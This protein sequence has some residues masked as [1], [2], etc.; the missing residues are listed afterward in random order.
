M[1]AKLLEKQNFIDKSILER[2]Q[3]GFAQT[4]AMM[5]KFELALAAIKQAVDSKPEW[6]GLRKI[7]ARIYAMA[8]EVNDALAQAEQ[9][10]EIAPQVVEGLIWFADFLTGLGKTDEAEDKL[11]KSIENHADNLML[12]AKFAEILM[13]NGKEND[14][15]EIAESIKSMLS[16][17]LSDAELVEAAGVLEKIGESG[18]VQK[19]LE[20]RAKKN[21]S[22][23][24]WIDLAGYEYRQEQF[25]N[26]LE[27]LENMEVDQD[28]SRLVNCLKADVLVK[29]GN[30]ENA[31][32][33][34]NAGA[35]T[36]YE[37]D[38]DQQMLFAPDQW[39]H[40]AGSLNPA[41]ELQTKIFLLQGKAKDSLDSVKKWIDFDADNNAARIMA[42]ESSFALGENPGQEY[43]QNIST[44]D[45]LEGDALHLIALKIE[46]LLDDDQV[47]DAQTL[48]EK[49]GNENNL[50]LKTVGIRIT[51]LSG[52]LAE[53][54]NN[55]DEI[56]SNQNGINSAEIPVK[57]GLNRM[58][59]T[60]SCALKRWNE[61]MSFSS[62][63][64]M[65]FGWNRKCVL[66]YLTTLVMAK[67]FEKISNELAIEVHN[68]SAFLQQ[69]NLDEEIN[70]LAELSGEESD[71]EVERWLLRGKMAAA[72]EAE[73]I[74]EFALVTP[75]PEDAA[76]MIAALHESGQDSTAIQVAKK[77]PSNSRVLM[78]LARIQSRSDLNAALETLN[79]LISNEPL[80]PAAL[81]LRSTV[82]EKIDKI[83][84]A[85]NDL[86]QAI[87][88]WPNES[89]WR[90]SSAKL[91]QQ[92]GNNTNAV[93]QLQ[94]AYEIKP[95]DPKI[96][97]E[98]SR[99]KVY[100]GELEAAIEI[101]KPVTQNN[102][103]LY[104]A[105]E[106]MADAHARCDQMEEALEAAQKAMEI[107]PFSTKPY[108]MSGKI[109][110]DNGNL[111]T[112]LDQAKLAFSQKKDNAEAILFL[113]KV[114]YQ[115][116]EKQQA[117]ATLEL[118]N[119]CENVTVQTMIEHVNLV[120]EINGGAYAK[121]L[122]ASLS[123]KYPENVELL[124]ILASAQVDN[125]DTEDAEQTAKRALQVDPDEP[126]LHLFLGKINAESGQL[127][128]AIHHLSQ[129]IAH[130]S[131]QTEGYLLL[132]KVY[133][134]QREFTKALD[135]LNQAMEVSPTD[136]RSYV[137]A[138]NLYR[139]SKN[140]SAAEKVLQKAVEID[141]KDVTIRRQLG[142]LLALKLV[143]HS[144]ETSSQS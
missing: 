39:K 52:H 124:K 31:F 63:A 136:T 77:F 69:I 103:N 111:D 26:A 129:G 79:T 27:V 90:L 113:A 106:L 55:F 41:L 92:Y 13:K 80:N 143:H 98:L 130:K 112:A 30:L 117:L 134:Q 51:I 137:A 1:Y 9:V 141:P 105:W 83:D 75:T 114:L 36:D 101:L 126:D 62:D 91:W 59:V 139:S 3:A 96:A 20:Y 104:E 88:D 85:I 86:E 68:P 81:V 144:Q 107:N 127:D 14:A 109:H 15:S 82:Y 33:L 61:A 97:M 102:P 54:E 125:G 135:A 40:L 25:A 34:L 50:S 122:I 72:P 121:E 120:K 7:L 58:L 115:R 95:D 56:L 22:F 10:L 17:E 29:T 110:L 116:G 37:L 57:M 6:V 32:E 42:I 16:I 35:S 87:S 45:K 71:K 73:T 18:S 23:A 46:S 123:Y 119:K 99:A 100:E 66:Q 140:Y 24:A 47:I 21:G 131:G 138:A 93:N 76:A 19:C 28:N 128:Q 64:A 8:G 67:E 142:A 60:A 49:T 11:R 5:G 38:I 133:E 65:K 108:L 2:I 84:L 118:T 48:L 12:K 4:S 43:F 44:N 132:S 78:E 53:A 74:R 70:R 94:A 89:N